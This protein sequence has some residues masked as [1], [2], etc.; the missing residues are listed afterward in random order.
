MGKVIPI[1]SDMTAKSA[2]APTPAATLITDCKT[3]YRSYGAHVWIVWGS[4]NRFACC[5]HCKAHRFDPDGVKVM[6]RWELL[7]G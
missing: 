3:R 6:M 5:I 7:G 1:R 4:D 2:P